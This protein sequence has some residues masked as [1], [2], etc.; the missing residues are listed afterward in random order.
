VPEIRFAVAE[1][2]FDIANVET[3]VRGALGELLLL[4]E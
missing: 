1:P 2:D 3:A 4:V